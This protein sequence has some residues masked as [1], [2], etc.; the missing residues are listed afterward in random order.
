METSLLVGDEA[1]R[2]LADDAFRASYAR[3]YERCPW[4]T[5]FQHL[6]FLD[7]W[8]AVYRQ[9]HAPILA[10]VHRRGELYG[11]LPLARSATGGLVAAGAH[12]AEYQCWLSEAAASNVVAEGIFTALRRAFPGRTLQLRY[13][14]PGVPPLSD[15]RHLSLT[16]HP[17]PFIDTARAV[18]RT[19]QRNKINNLN[20]LGTLHFEQLTALAD[21][22]RYQDAIELQYNLRQ[23]FADLSRGFLADPHKRALHERLFERGLLHVTLLRLDDELL[24]A[25]LGLH[26][27]NQVHLGVFSSHVYR[28]YSKRSPGIVHILLL[29]EH[30]R[31]QGIGQLDLTPG[32]EYKD[33][34][35]NARD[36]AYTLTVHPGRAAAWS[37][38]LRGAVRRA[39]KAALMHTGVAPAGLRQRLALPSFGKAPTPV[40]LGAPAGADWGHPPPARDPLPDILLYHPTSRGQPGRAAFLRQAVA[41]LEAGQRLFTQAHDGAL[42]AWAFAWLPGGDEADEARAALPSGAVL[43]QHLGFARGAPEEQRARF[44]REILAALAQEPAVRS[45][46]VEAR[47]PAQRRLLTGLGLCTSGSAGSLR[48]QP[49]PT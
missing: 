24:A 28:R 3:L 11:A 7:V 27:R 30:L 49:R 32:G 13:L 26:G 42:R 15:A 43:V 23:G 40:L 29:A 5:A 34:V 19:K 44:V 47:G 22:R 39:G 37:A 4:A 21:Y 6:D 46:W 38:G 2:T 16:A 31:A 17:R 8:Y 48:A 35:A 12:Q 36:T 9:S 45:L 41:H 33:E 10:L 25:N 14:P 1:L 18:L 20:R